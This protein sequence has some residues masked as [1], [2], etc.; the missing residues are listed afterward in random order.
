MMLD[1]QGMVGTTA[2]GMAILAGLLALVDRWASRQLPPAIM[3]L[4]TASGLILLTRPQPL[5]KRPRLRLLRQR[6]TRVLLVG[7]T[8]LVSVV[9]GANLFAL[10]LA[11]GVPLIPR[12][13]Q[14]AAATDVVSGSIAPLDVLAMLIMT[15]VLTG[16]LLTHSG[17][18]RR[19]ALLAVALGFLLPNAD[20][21]FALLRG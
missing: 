17:W 7:M 6:G 2:S 9:A 5:P 3:P 20:L 1:L 18:P 14:A 16:F 8:W 11:L 19:E 4:T 13:A 21:W 15:C 12:L 10:S